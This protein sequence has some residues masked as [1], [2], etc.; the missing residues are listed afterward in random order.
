M[1]AP[2]E[3]PQENRQLTRRSALAAI[4]AS[5]LTPYVP[6][7]FAVRARREPV[8]LRVL[9]TH[10]TLQE[11]IRVAAQQDLGIH[12]E[13]A[14]GGSAS[15]LQQ[16]STRP[17]TFD[18]YEQWS[19]SINVLWRAD[20]IQPLDVSRI[21]RWNEVNAL[22]KTGHL[23]PDAPI[24]KGDAPHT[25]LYVQ[26]DTSL[27]SAAT[28]HV[29]FLPY[30]HNADSFGYDTRVVPAGE[31]YTDESWSWLLDERWHGRVAIVNEPTIGIFDAAMAVQARG[32]MSFADIGNMTYAEIDQ[33]FEILVDYKRRGHFTG[34]WSSVPESVRF[35]QSG[36][37]VIESMFSPGAASLRGL[38]I[39]VRYAA[40]REGY[41]AWH[42]V[43]CVSSRTRASALDA[44]YD[45]M[46]WW[47]DGTP[48]AIM[49][50]QGYYISVPETARS[51][52]STDEWAFWYEGRPAEKAIHG[53]D[54]KI[55][56]APGELRHGGS[57]QQRFE[58]VAV[59]NTVM[60]AYEHSML[61]WGEFLNADPRSSAR[62]VTGAA[63]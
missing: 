53:T 21:N 32:L 27:G 19:N 5:A 29:S 23:T 34:V 24:G 40:P 49:A 62:H 1:E 46:N 41:R 30:V 38:G 6:K 58:N 25:L 63:R 16:A 47:L 3:A 44:A 45:Y 52:M 54:G 50:R 36:R 10:V 20:A 43:M 37:A 59:W 4:S 60:D 33:L 14:P 11:Q 48:G 9:G 8:T 57:Y 2:D 22:S 13:F 12:I 31:A 56:A 26:P 15:V 18:V 17:E 35:M 42:G 51:H 55:I 39:P 7:A 28:S 61:R